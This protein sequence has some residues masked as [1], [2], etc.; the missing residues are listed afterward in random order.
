MF[1]ARTLRS[2]IFLLILLSIAAV[3]LAS[4]VSMRSIT[5]Q[6]FARQQ[7]SSLSWKPFAQA[8]RVRLQ[9][10]AHIGRLIATDAYLIEAW[11]RSR[12][13]IQA[14]A[15]AVRQSKSDTKVL[16]E[17][18]LKCL[19]SIWDISQRLFLESDP[20]PDQT[21]YAACADLCL[22][23]DD[24]GVVVLEAMT[25]NDPA[26]PD[27]GKVEVHF[28]LE[29]QRQPT[30]QKIDLGQNSLIQAALHSGRPMA[31]YW[32]YGSDLYQAVGVPSDVGLVLLADRVDQQL[33]RE[34]SHLVGEADSLALTAEKILAESF[35]SQSVGEAELRRALGRLGDS[36]ETREFR[37]PGA[38]Y[39]AECYPL[40]SE[41]R[42]LDSD[43]VSSKQLGWMLFLKTTEELES[44]A[45]RQAGVTVAVV[46]GAALLGLVLATPLANLIAR[47]LEKLSQAMARVGEGDLDARAASSGP[48]EIVSAAQAFNGMVEG[49]RQ[50]E[51]LEKFVD[52]LEQLRKA[53]DVQDPLVRD[54]TQFGQY[55]VARRL[56]AGGMATVY[57]GLP[58]STLDE[59]G[60]VAIKVIH[61]SVADDPEY[62]A[63]FQREFQVMQRLQHPGLVR[64][65]ESGQ[66][67][68]LL[69]IAMEYVEGQDLR[70]YL[71]D[72]GELGEQEFLELAGPILEA[73]QAAHE[74]GVTHRDLKPENVMITQGTIK[75][76]DFG[77]AT[78]SGASR[79]TR[80]GDTVGTPLYMAPEQVRGAPCEARSDQ[81]SLGVMFFEMLTGI[82]PFQSEH[83]MGL[84]LKHMSD[85]PPRP[86]DI[87][88]DVP[89]KFER[90]ILKMLS[91]NPDDRYPDL[92]AVKSELTS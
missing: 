15:L 33:V 51:T 6:A 20:N 48:V 37:L 61:R 63:R 27:F 3:S 89:E 10:L 16:E 32:T 9:D 12:K 35:R 42:E 38:G 67:N 57:A 7:R 72:K 64:V 36:P 86:R 90:V 40:S 79:L 14:Y 83:P 46:L 54:Q 43:E 52:R 76:M 31:A 53:A 29:L 19:P 68:G 56:G 80:S 82:T 92:L 21:I 70:E 75:I 71:N 77:L 84:I 87:R 17:L 47:P 23:C 2:Q 74:A 50:K 4:L 58:V 26:R 8:R 11:R 78:A 45:R 39:V 91:K 69:Y 28:P 85:P 49:L 55:V 44:V 65:I 1:W 18:R 59:A 30:P 22:L 25:G 5:Y 62:Q 13:D 88:S 41:P 34:A 24:E 66:L 73:V 81:Y 60:R